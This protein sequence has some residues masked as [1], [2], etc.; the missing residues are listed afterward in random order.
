MGFADQAYTEFQAAEII[1][2]QRQ[3]ESG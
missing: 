3:R 1:T 2:K